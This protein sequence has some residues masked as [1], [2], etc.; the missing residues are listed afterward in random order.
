MQDMISASQV[1]LVV[2]C[3][4]T[5][6]RGIIRKGWCLPPYKDPL[7][8]KKYLVGIIDGT[9]WCLKKENRV[10]Y[11]QVAEEPTKPILAKMLKKEMLK[12][13]ASEA[14]KI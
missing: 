6:Y 4:K 14:G 9:Y 7:I 5:L 3:K 2:R 13:E 8:T 12:Q 1:A 10:L 11:Q